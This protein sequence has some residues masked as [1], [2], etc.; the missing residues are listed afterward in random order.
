MRVFIAIELSN[1]IK[2]ELLALQQIVIEKASA[3]KFTSLENFHLTVHFIGDVNERDYDSIKAAMDKAAEK[4]S[5]FKLTLTNLGSFKKK[6]KEIIWL[7]VN[8]ELTFL[9]NLNKEV[10]NHLNS[11]SSAGPES[12]YIPHITLGRQVRLN[13]SIHSLNKSLPIPNETIAVESISLME[14]KRVNNKL[15][16]EPIYKVRLPGAY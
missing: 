2:S 16:Y 11:F 1:K 13:T 9:Q 4:L 10:V 14:S 7:G 3:G 15:V 8:G 6:N 5:P 12:T